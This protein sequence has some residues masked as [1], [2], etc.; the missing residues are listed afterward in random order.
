M[1]TATRNRSKSAP[2]TR[3]P[4][5]QPNAMPANVIVTVFLDGEEV[6][7]VEIPQNAKLS[8]SDNVTYRG[9]ISGGWE[10]DGEPTETLGLLTFV[11][12]GTR[13]SVG[14]EG[15]HQSKSKNP[16]V[17]HSGVVELEVNGGEP[18]RYSVRLYATYSVKHEGY[19]LSIDAWPA[20]VGQPRGPQVVGTIG[21]G[22]VLR[23]AKKAA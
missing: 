3:K 10:L 16:T 21:S 14:T 22:F 12:Q 1:A 8:P 11:A 13:L 17:F 2:D 4:N 19:S 7:P 15:V 23:P 6:G 9:G 20:P 5:L 18:R